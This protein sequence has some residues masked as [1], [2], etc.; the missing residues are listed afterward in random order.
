[1]RQLLNVAYAARAAGLDAGELRSLDEQIGM[2]EDPEELAKEA[3]TAHQ[4]AMGMTFDDEP[5]PETALNEEAGIDI[6]YD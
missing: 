2:A 5:D 1:V 3:L 4:E 6:S